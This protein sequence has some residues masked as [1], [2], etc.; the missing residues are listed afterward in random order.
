M[1]NKVETE[2]ERVRESSLV[3]VRLSGLTHTGLS[4]EEAV[5]GPIYGD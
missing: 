5:G 4:G 2:R 3:T 1:S